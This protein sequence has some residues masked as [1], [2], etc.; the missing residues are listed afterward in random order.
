MQRDHQI[1]I[2]RV[3]FSGAVLHFTPALRTSP[4]FGRDR[5]G[6]GQL[7]GDVW[8]QDINCPQWCGQKDWFQQGP[9]WYAPWQWRARCVF[10]FSSFSVLFLEKAD[11]RSICL[12]IVA[13]IDPHVWEVTGN[14]WKP[15]QSNNSEGIHT[16]L[17]HFEHGRIHKGLWLSWNLIIFDESW[18]IL[19]LT[20]WKFVHANTW[21]SNIRQ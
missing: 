2:F 18:I 11:G 4:P 21:K 14:G 10:S 15:L 20:W 1:N 13:Y 7:A 9:V 19:H 16:N 8:E 12:G 3:S 5:L 6:C 17:G